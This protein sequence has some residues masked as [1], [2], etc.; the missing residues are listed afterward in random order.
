MIRHPF[1]LVA[2]I[3]VLCCGIVVMLASVALQTRS[4]SACRIEARP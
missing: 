2:S 3:V 4:P 1:L